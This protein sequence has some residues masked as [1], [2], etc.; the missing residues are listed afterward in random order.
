MSGLA[1]EQLYEYTCNITGTVEYGASLEAILAGENPPPPG[2]LRVD[3]AFEGPVTG[4]LNGG[5]IGVD[6]LNLRAD[7]RIDL[8]IK[9]DITTGDGD[10]IALAASGVAIRR[11]DS[12]VFSLRE[13]VKLT[14]ASQ[15]A[16]WV[17]PLQIWGVGSVDLST[18]EI[19]IKG[20]L[21]E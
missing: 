15:N 10:K 12:P 13:N 6:Y 4:R 17:N 21:P 20:Y 2:G 14:T 1:A 16:S 11:G 3:V 7:G 19:N 5:V 9:A 8:D 18:G